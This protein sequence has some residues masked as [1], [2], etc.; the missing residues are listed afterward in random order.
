MRK[1]YRTYVRRSKPFYT[2]FR[3][4]LGPHPPEHGVHPPLHRRVLHEGDGA[5][6]QAVPQGEVA[7]ERHVVAAVG[8]TPIQEHHLDPVRT[9]QVLGHQIRLRRLGP[10]SDQVAQHVG[11]VPATPDEHEIADPSRD[12]RGGCGIPPGRQRPTEQQHQVD[13]LGLGILER[14]PRRDGVQPVHVAHT[15]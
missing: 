5:W 2:A 8:R 6:A 13:V 3:H 15:R 11:G 14:K 12:H 1:I 4:R 9:P 10:G 7:G